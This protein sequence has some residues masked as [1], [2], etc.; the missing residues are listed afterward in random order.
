MKSRRQTP[1]ASYPLEDYSPFDGRTGRHRKPAHWQ[2]TDN[3]W[4]LASGVLWT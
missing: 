1:D 4:R 3:Y 2:L